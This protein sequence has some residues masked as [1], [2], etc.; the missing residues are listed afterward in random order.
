MKKLAI[1]VLTACTLVASWAMYTSQQKAKV[2]L[3]PFAQQNEKEGEGG[4]TD[5]PD[6]AI[7]QDY[8]MRYDPAINRVPT[9]RLI[10]A[11]TSSQNYTNSITQQV[12][13]F[14]IGRPFFW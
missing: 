4:E 3:L 7:K 1:L 10:A 11:Q 12:D 8:L 9:E 14:L 2:S 6:Q 5:S 13:L